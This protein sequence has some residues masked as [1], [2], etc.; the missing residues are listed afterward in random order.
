VEDLVPI[1]VLRPGE[2]AEIGAIL[3]KPEDVHRLEEM[4]LR[5]GTSVEMISSGAPCVIRLGAQKLCFRAD[6]LLSIM[7]RPGIGT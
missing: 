6:E 3:G 5:G 1:N 7:V 4:G 2:I